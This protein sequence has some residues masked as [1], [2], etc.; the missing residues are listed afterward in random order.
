LRRGAAGARGV[1]RWAPP[2]A[3]IALLAAVA[4]VVIGS[5]DAREPADWAFRN[6]RILTLDGVRGGP[7]AAGAPTRALGAPVAAMAVRGSRIVFLGDEAGLAEW[8]GASTR[9]VDLQGRT[10]APGFIDA[11]F[12]LRN[13]GTYLQTVNLVGTKSWQE[14]VDRVVDAAKTSP[15]GAWIVGRGWDQNDWET[16]EFPTRA[17]IDSL[18]PGR[19]VYLRRI[20]GHA[21]L[22]SGA[23]LERAGL[24]PDT[25][26]PPGGRMLKDASGRLT[27]VLIDAAVS[28]VASIVPEPTPSERE[29]LLVLAARTCA[30]AG[31]TGVHDMST[32]AE[33][34]A[35]LESLD[36]QGRLPIRV[37]AYIDASDPAL[38][39]L[40]EAGPRLAAGEA[41]LAVRGVK[42][43]LDG[44]LGSRGAALSEPYA[45][46]PGNVGLLQMEPD[47]Y[48]SLVRLAWE[49]G[50]QVATHAIGDRANRIVLDT[51]ESLMAADAPGADRR[52]RIEHAQHLAPGDIARFGALGV[53]ASM[54][55][56]HATSDMP[57]AE[58]RVGPE[59]IRGAYAWRSLARGGARLAFGS[60][61]PVES[62]EPQL[63]L[64]AAVTRCDA[65]GSP[66]G[67][68]RPDERLA[69]L[70]AL[71][72]F[73]S[74]AAH[75]AFEEGRLGTL[76]VG[77]EADFVFLSA[78]PLDV[79]PPELLR[80]RVLGTWVGGRLVAADPRAGLGF[81][82]S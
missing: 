28:A 24:G 7:A 4:L 29:S 19:P 44:A 58:A 57:W 11:H 55:P 74:G 72:A 3:P 80:M 9:V 81:G 35:A 37:N 66:S 42:I 32:D 43:L 50:F 63:G 45:D 65:S 62:H 2:L 76:R 6:G 14:V 70:E 75:A 10:L 18:L 38:L 68:W 67:G 48:T 78:S 61:C 51:Y 30:A 25:P 71:E 47:A 54:Q 53:I 40:L 52:P 73:T 1:P 82:G 33:T 36:R 59:R 56:T 49:R 22:V 23:A 15:V 46:D 26:E 17:A 12:H 41:R 21:A 39:R 13:F 77:K 31:L 69:A 27:G 20:D 64:Y 79:E 16:R 5:G 60:D 34:I 8:I